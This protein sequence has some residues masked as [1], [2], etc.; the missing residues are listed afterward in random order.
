VAVF[1]CQCLPI[2][3]AVFENF[4]ICRKTLLNKGFGRFSDFGIEN[5][6]ICQL[7][8]MASAGTKKQYG[9]VLLSNSLLMECL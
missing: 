2:G 5:M 4:T 3:L 1:V 8:Y 9:C 7:A 6:P